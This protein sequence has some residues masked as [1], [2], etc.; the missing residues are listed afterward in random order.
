M[1]EGNIVNIGIVGC[2][3]LPQ[4]VLLPCVAAIPKLNLI[5]TC[6]LD[7]G[8]AE[9]VAR[10]YGAGTWTTDWREL[11]EVKELDGVM[12]VAPP[13]IHE[14]VGIATLERGLHLFL[15]KPPSMTAEGAR[16]LFEASRGT[17]LKTLVGT[18]QRHTPACRMAKEITQREDFGR[19]LLYQARYCTPG[20]GMRMDWGMDRD[21]EDEMLHFFLLDHII[22]HIDLTRFF[23][24]EVDAVSALRTEG[25]PDRYAFAASVKFASGVSCSFRAPS[26]DNHVVIYGD[27]PVAVEVTNWSK[28]EYRA[29]DLPVGKG[30]YEDSPKVSWDGGISYQDGVMRPGYR[31]ELSFWA[32]GI[33]HGA[34]CHADVEDAW[35]DM[36]VLEALLESLQREK[37][38]KIKYGE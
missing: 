25:V 33:L 22:H 2:G 5:A 3:G 8:K 7:E 6:D 18:V 4:G 27:G 26:F 32:E 28:L 16:R 10:R 20:P 31:S 15:E 17:E 11:L 12:V 35:R 13:A 23:M 24:G 30:G 14:E 21:S 19:P 38:R 34:R 37:P 1:P 36:V 9:M 29:E